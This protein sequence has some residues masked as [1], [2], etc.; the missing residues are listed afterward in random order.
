MNFKNAWQHPRT[1]IAGLLVGIGIVTP[2]LMAH[3]IT[4]GHIGTGT[5]L[6]LIA[7]L[8]V[9]LL[10][11]LSKD[12]PDVSKPVA[13]LLLAPALFL[14]SACTDS[15]RQQA[16]QAAQNASIVVRGFQAGEIAAH[17]Q[18]LIPDVDHAVIQRELVD[19]ATVGKTADSCIRS[20]TGKP[21]IIACVDAAVAGVDSI[22][23][24]GGLY[25]KSDKAKT[26]FQ[27]AM[28]GV[29]SA[30]Q[31]LSTYLGGK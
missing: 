22:N 24:D 6:D 13:L 18:G 11:A 20:A 27:L 1:T 31:V 4:L 25:L 23:A 9:A 16:A 10:G 21:G 2:V 28:V 3:G 12:A 14:L 29:K 7:A 5:V 15:D 17:Q 19:V 30:L 8:A 26:E